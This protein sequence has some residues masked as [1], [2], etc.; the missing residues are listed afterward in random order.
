MSS[1]GKTGGEVKV[2]VVIPAFNEEG[3]LAGTLSQ[4]RAAMREF[5]GRGWDTELIVCDNNS[6]DRTAEVGRAGGAAVVFEPINQI[7]RARNT[8]AAAATGEWLVFV[9][10]DS[11]PSPEL[12]REVGDQIASGVCLAGGCTVKLE[13]DYALANWG[14]RLWNGLSRARKLMAGSFIFCD[15]TEFRGI[16]GFS[17]DRFAGE[18]LDLSWRLKRRARQVGKRIVILHRHPLLTS[19]R[20]VRLYSGWEHLRFLLRTIIGRGKTLRS[21]EGCPTW[22]DGRR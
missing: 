14:V 13:G 16:G 10:A 17:L 2:S 8:G 19:A 15:A 6:T 7:G 9:D 20:K 11:Q 21:R 1:S 3:L 18:E 22:Y 4:V 5:R 12:F